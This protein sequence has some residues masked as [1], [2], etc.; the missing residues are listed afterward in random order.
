MQINYR[1]GFGHLL[2]SRRKISFTSTRR[3][4]ISAFLLYFP[5]VLLLNI[6][7]RLTQTCGSYLKEEAEKTEKE[8]E[9]KPEPATPAGETTSTPRSIL[10]PTPGPLIAGPLI[11]ASP[12]EAT[13]TTT[14][15]APSS[16]PKPSLVDIRRTRAKSILDAL[17]PVD[18]D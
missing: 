13:D 15:V 6:L 14:G 11:D 18:S 1:L 2:S 9:K 8:D 16:V 12:T 5:L 4:S 7:Q 17:R 3:D 10:K